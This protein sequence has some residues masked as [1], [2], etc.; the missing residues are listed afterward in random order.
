MS[1]LFF[2]LSS[3]KGMTGYATTFG[4]RIQFIL[5]AALGAWKKGFKV[6]IR[7]TTIGDA[8]LL[9]SSLGRWLTTLRK[10]WNLEG[11]DWFTFLP[12]TRQ[13]LTAV[14]GMRSFFREVHRPGALAIWYEDSSLP[15]ST[16]RKVAVDIEA[17][18][19]ELVPGDV[20][21]PFIAYSP[22]FGSCPFLNEPR[23]QR[24][25]DKK[26]Y[27]TTRSYYAYEFGSASRFRGVISSF[28]SVSL[29]GFGWAKVGKNY[30]LIKGATMQEVPLT[31]V[32]SQSAWYNI[33]CRDCS[34]AY[35]SMFT[36]VQRYSPISSLAYMSKKTIQ[37]NIAMPQLDGEIFVAAVIAKKREVSGKKFLLPVDGEEEKEEGSENIVDE[38]DH[39][40]S[41][42]EVLDSSTDQDTSVL[43]NTLSMVDIN[44]PVTTE[45]TVPRSLMQELRDVRERRKEEQEQVAIESREAK[46]QKKKE[47]E[48]K[49]RKKVKS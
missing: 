36:A 17:A 12:P 22:I 1:L 6:D 28:G 42:E 47:K 16:E 39:S 3:M 19:R 40:G 18:S 11:E 32:K 24:S 14:Q 29:Y 35:L 10:S 27:P 45:T 5:A 20:L 38:V 8:P 30:D 2:E 49:K 7:L 9:L 37:L 23:V 4:K 43:T 34:A 15:T 31:L 46:L 44:L 25:E 21:G 41:E 48:Q 33:V 26:V 13:P